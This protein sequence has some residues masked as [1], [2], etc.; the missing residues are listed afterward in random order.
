MECDCE[1]VALW[2]TGSIVN[3][4]E[5]HRTIFRLPYQDRGATFF[6]GAASLSEKT[7]VAALIILKTPKPTANLTRQLQTVHV[8]TSQPLGS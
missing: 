5:E 7:L 2:H 6:M 1:L 8:H 3:F 4:S